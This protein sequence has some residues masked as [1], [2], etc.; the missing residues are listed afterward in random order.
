MEQFISPFS[1]RL[2]ELTTK[3]QLDMP[4]IPSLH[5]DEPVNMVSNNDYNAQ[6]LDYNARKSQVIDKF[7]AGKDAVAAKAMEL[8]QA[9]QLGQISP[10]DAEAELDNFISNQVNN[11]Y[12][13]YTDKMAQLNSV[14]PAEPTQSI[15]VSG[16]L[17]N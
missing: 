7:N 4:V 2:K 17:M 10:Q 14:N 16:V 15:N 13:G 11:D 5:K 6:E 9:M 8:K 12:A 1:K 3:P